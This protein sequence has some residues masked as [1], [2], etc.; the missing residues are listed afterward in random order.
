MRALKHIGLLDSGKVFVLPTKPC[1]FSPKMKRPNFCVDPNGC[2]SIAELF[3][4][5]VHILRLSGHCPLSYDRSTRLKKNPGE[6]LG[7]EP[8]AIHGVYTFQWHN[9]WTGWTAICLLLYC[10][11]WAIFVIEG[12]TE[13]RIW[14]NEGLVLHVI[15]PCFHRFHSVNHKFKIDFYPL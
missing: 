10:S 4:P 8:P 12:V 1:G 3:K 6:P 2:N 11:M 5:L 15:I 7:Y 9:R 13:F 14:S